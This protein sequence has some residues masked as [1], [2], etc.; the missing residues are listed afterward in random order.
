MNPQKFKEI[1]DQVQKI[2]H[3]GIVSTSRKT[4][5]EIID[6]PKGQMWIASKR[7]QRLLN[8]IKKQYDTGTEKSER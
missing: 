2:N 5:Y 3:E 1:L 4:N 8:E 7:K 6:T